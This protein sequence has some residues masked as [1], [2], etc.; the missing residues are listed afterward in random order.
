MQLF[1]VYKK[2]TLITLLLVI[3]IGSAS[4]FLIIT[5]FVHHSAD[6]TLKEYQQNIKTYVAQHGIPIFIDNPLLDKSRI[7]WEAQDSDVIVKE[8]LRDTLVYS[9]YKQEQ[10]VFRVLSYTLQQGDANY[11]VTLWQ[12][13][14]DSD[15]ILLAVIVSLI[16]LFVLFFLFYFWLTKWFINHLWQ[17]FY[18]ILEQ[19]KKVDLTTPCTINV[20]TH[21]VDEFI[22]LQ[23]TLNKMLVRIHEDYVS[24]KELTE[25]SSHELQTPLSIIKARLELMQQSDDVSEKQRVLIQSVSTAVDRVIRLN[26][27]MLIIAKINNDQ[28]PAHTKVILN[29]FINDFLVAYEDVI[30]MKNLTITK[31][32]SALMMADLHPQLAEILVSNLLSNAIRYN[33]AQGSICICST[34]HSFTISNPYC[35]I[36]PQG[37]LFVRFKKSASTTDATGLGLAIVRSICQKNDLTVSVEITPELF[38]I[39]V[40]QRQPDQSTPSPSQ[41]SV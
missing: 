4:H 11:L 16:I 20:S 32:Y 24:L 33:V 26:R 13:T 18:L 31:H 30:E 41:Q 36:I 14:L 17:P 1:K 2:Y 40:T 6:H 8:Y 27:F 28:F 9:T 10:V 38:C 21:Q 7:T 19:L 3:L 29:D 5:Y 35:N 34:A 37:D 15:D 39:I 22:T 25:T 23:N 12:A